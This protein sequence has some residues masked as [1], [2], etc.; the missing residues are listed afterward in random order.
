MYLL[1]EPRVVRPYFE[2]REPDFVNED[3]S[4]YSW[5]RSLGRNS[6]ESTKV[7]EH[8]LLTSWTYAEADAF[9]YWTA[10]RGVQRLNAC[11]QWRTESVQHSHGGDW[12]QPSQSSLSPIVQAHLH[13][14]S[15]RD[16]VTIEDEE[17]VTS[18][19]FDEYMMSYLPVW[20][21]C[22][23]RLSLESGLIQARLSNLNIN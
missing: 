10:H 23:R 6:P 5:L 22:K 20:K 8:I 1:I 16:W 14:F 15:L 19:H 13:K 11:V 3:V 12:G 9:R 21:K 17:I 2:H 7:C 18:N 4:V